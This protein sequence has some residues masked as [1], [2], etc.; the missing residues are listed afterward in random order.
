MTQI[1]HKKT[2]LFDSES[3][4]FSDLLAY[5]RTTIHKTGKTGCNLMMSIIISYFYILH[6][7]FITTTVF[8]EKASCKI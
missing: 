3:L 4:K 7:V 5:Y 1:L 2:G 8:K 6:Y